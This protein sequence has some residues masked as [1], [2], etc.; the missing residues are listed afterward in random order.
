LETAHIALGKSDHMMAPFPI[1]NPQPV[2]SRLSRALLCRH[3][4]WDDWGR[5]APVAYSLFPIMQF[6]LG[7]SIIHVDDSMKPLENDESFSIFIFIT[8]RAIPNHTG[9]SGMTSS[10]SPD[11]LLEHACEL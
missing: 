1:T 11:N 10:E 4:Y 2:C 6:L 7:R 8:A 5:K 9:S 3:T